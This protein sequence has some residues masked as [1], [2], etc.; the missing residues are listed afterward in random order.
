MVYPKLQIIIDHLKNLDNSP[1]SKLGFDMNWEHFET[2]RST[3]PCGSACCIGGH[4]A[5][6]LGEDY[7][8]SIT[9]AV[10][11]LCEVPDNVARKICWPSG[12]YRAPLENAIEM[13]EKCRD[14][15]MVDWSC[16]GKYEPT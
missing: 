16:D 12:Y 2:R 3:H 4:A 8:G 15:G 9:D 11:E 13:L 6:L 14:T 1:K 10:E 5:I 7:E